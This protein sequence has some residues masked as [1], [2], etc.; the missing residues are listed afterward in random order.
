MLVWWKVR[1]FCMLTGIAMLSFAY[2]WSR[3]N[4]VLHESVIIFPP[5][6]IQLETHRGFPGLCLSITRR[7]IRLKVLQDVVIHEGL[8]GWDVRYYLAAIKH[9]ESGTFALEIAYQNLLPQL[10]VLQHVY[11]GI[12]DRLLRPPSCLANVAT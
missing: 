12:H 7:F 6:G 1:D 11:R 2:L 5:H 9:A 3:C 8:K 4:Q 10:A